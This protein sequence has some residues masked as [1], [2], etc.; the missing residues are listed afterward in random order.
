GNLL[1]IP[2]S[3]SSFLSAS[4][5]TT[6]E[7]KEREYIVKMLRECGGVIGGAKGAAARLGLKRTTLNARIRKHGITRAEL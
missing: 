2:I 4:T 7:A 1:Q 6:L 5:P 3:D